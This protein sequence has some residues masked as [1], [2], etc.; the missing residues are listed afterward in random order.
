MLLPILQL[1]QSLGWLVRQTPSPP[2]LEITDLKSY[3]ETYLTKHFYSLVY[4]D[5]AAR[6]SLGL[7][8]MVSVIHNYEYTTLTYET[9]VVTRPM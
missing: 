6:Q 3:L 5:Q 7:L 8:H 2:E 9:M 1:V 4:Q